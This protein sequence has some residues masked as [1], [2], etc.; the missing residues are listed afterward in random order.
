MKKVYI[1]NNTGAIIIV[2][3]KNDIEY[4]NN[5]IYTLLF[6]GYYKQCLSNIEEYFT[7]NFIPDDQQQII[8]D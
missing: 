2:S 8:N 5:N 4:I 7:N 1:N 3:A 6:E